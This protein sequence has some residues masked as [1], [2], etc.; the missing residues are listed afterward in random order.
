MNRSSSVSAART[1]SEHLQDPPCRVCGHVEKL[2]VPNGHPFMLKTSDVFEA[3]EIHLGDDPTG[4][5]AFRLLTVL[6]VDNPGVLL[7][8]IATTERL[9]PTS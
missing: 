7:D 1:Q 4:D 3:L 9:Y 6:A 8:T 5:L 2:H